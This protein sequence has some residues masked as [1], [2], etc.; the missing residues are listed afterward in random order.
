MKT[1]EEGSAFRLSLLPFAV[2]FSLSDGGTGRGDFRRL[3]SGSYEVIHEYVI[4]LNALK[5]HRDSS[6][7]FN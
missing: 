5:M 7:S 2:A 1:I 6:G 4:F 3:N